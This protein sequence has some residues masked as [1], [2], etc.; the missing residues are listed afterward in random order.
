MLRL[1]RLVM[2][3]FNGLKEEVIIESP[4]AQIT[5]DGEGIRQVQLGLTR[6]YLLVGKDNFD[7]AE[8]ESLS[9]I[10]FKADIE[11]EFESMRLIQIIPLKAIRI[12]VYRRDS[13]ELLKIIAGNNSK[14]IY[15]EFGGH[16]LRRMYW[17][18]WKDRI[19]NPYTDIETPL[20]SNSE[21]EMPKKL[22]VLVEVHSK[23]KKIVLNEN[24]K[25]QQDVETNMNY[26]Y[27]ETKSSIEKT[28]YSVLKSHSDND[29][30]IDLS[31]QK[32]STDDEGTLNRK[33][34]STGLIRL[35]Y[36]DK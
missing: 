15:F 31:Q 24:G 13:R 36:L 23:F 10:Y 6:K 28:G 16:L 35:C 30:I 25:D 7:K 29:Y 22:Q 8:T 21:N 5:Q 34:V 19:E 11:P 14:I 4:F 12:K 27:H 1:C 9:N 18:I 20:T 32:N 2:D 17:N 26:Y 3:E 33:S